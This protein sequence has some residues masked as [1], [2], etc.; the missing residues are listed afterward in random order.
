M[1]DTADV[2]S[3]E[4]ARLARLATDATWEIVEGRGYQTAFIDYPGSI[5][6]FFVKLP[7]GAAMHKH[8]DCGDCQTDHVVISTNDKCFNWWDEDQSVHME[9]GKRYTV[10]RTLLHWATNDGETDRVHLLV[11]Y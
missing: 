11:E 9:A 4:I 10:D 7:P 1:T 3:G 8:R 5:R 2:G 6:A